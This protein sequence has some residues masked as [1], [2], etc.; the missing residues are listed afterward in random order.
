MRST[1]ALTAANKRLVPGHQP[2]Q[3]VGTVLGLDDQVDGDEL[4]RRTGAGHHHDL[5]GAGEGRGHADDPADLAFRL[6]DIGVAGAGDDVD[7][8]HRVPVPKAMAA[9]A[10]APPMR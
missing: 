4:G 10:W 3:A 6:G 8:G 1:S 2:G 9:T 7:P 5:R